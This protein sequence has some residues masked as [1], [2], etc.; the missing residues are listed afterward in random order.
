[1]TTVR[2]SNT[3]PPQACSVL[4]AEKNHSDCQEVFRDSVTGVR[5]HPMISPE[6]RSFMENNPTFASILSA[7]LCGPI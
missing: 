3:P 5:H 2:L 1:M 7:K 4:W 6:P